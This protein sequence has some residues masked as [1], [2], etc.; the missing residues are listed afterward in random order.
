VIEE[1]RTER[2]LVV[3]RRVR[4]E[5]R[6]PEDDDSNT[7]EEEPVVRSKEPRSAREQ[8]SEYTFEEAQE[9][10]GNSLT[11]H[12]RLGEGG[13]SVSYNFKKI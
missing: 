7:H 2:E 13:G 10:A 11:I 8:M 9:M 3:S 5:D 6:S 1:P 4:L 12:G